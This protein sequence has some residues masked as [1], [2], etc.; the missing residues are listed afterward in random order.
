M[1]RSVLPRLENP[2]VTVEEG[3]H[4]IGRVSLQTTVDCYIIEITPDGNIQTAYK[5]NDNPADG[6]WTAWAVPISSWGEVIEKYHMR[7]VNAQ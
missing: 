4:W 7:L 1:V 2:A 6:E 5:F 3:Q